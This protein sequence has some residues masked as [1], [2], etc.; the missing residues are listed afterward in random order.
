MDGSDSQALNSV[1]GM[2]ALVNQYRNQM[3]QQ[4]LFVSSGDNYIPGPRFNAA[5]DASLTSLLGTPDVGRAD[6]AL[7]NAMGLQ[8][9]VIGNHELDLGVRQFTEIMRPSGQWQG[10][11]FPYLSY[12]VD[13]SADSN[14]NPLRVANGGSAADQAGKLTGWTQVNVGDQIIGVIG[15]SSP[16]F[17]NITTVDNLDFKPTIAGSAIDIDGLAAEIQRGV[18]EMSAAGIKKIVLLSHMQQIQVEKQLATKL[19]NVDIIVAGGSNTL[20]ANSGDTLRTGDVSA[21]SY[22]FLTQS[23]SGQPVVVVNVDGDYKYL[24]RF[25]APFDSDGVLIP[26]RFESTQSGPK[27]TAVNLDNTAASGAV[28]RVVEIRDALRAVLAAKDGNVFG[29]TSVFLEGRRAFVRNQETNFGNLTA[30]ANLWYANLHQ[31]ATQV[32]ISLK[33]GGG[34]RAEIGDVAAQPGSVTGFTLEP[35]KENPG[36]RQQGQIS[37]LA[38]ETSLK[39]NN[40]LWV[41]DVT[42]EQLKQLLEHGVAALGSQGRFP[43]VGGMSF[44]YDPARQAQVLSNFVVTT[45]GERIRSLKVGSETVVQDGAILGDPNRNF[46]LVTLNFLAGRGDGYPFPADLANL[47]K[48]DEVMDQNTSGGAVSTSTAG[49]GRE[50]DALMKYLR[51][52]HTATPFNIPDTSE[53]LDIR[54]QNLSKR[55]DSLLAP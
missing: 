9:S 18:D 54:I 51:E 3:P 36:I 32:Q 22:P 5:N 47:V 28:Q 33:N 26:E 39:F 41:F 30:D 48:L 7:L 31:Q 4:T 50:Q 27:V 29:S 15:A 44:S 35:P 34:I 55:A 24:G 40:R 23:A 1:A 38:V 13:F 37:Q 43:Q 53:E 52:F 19:R 25:I 11:Q 12:N 10:A 14:A 20:L 16:V 8:A 17:K 6:I 21:G 49:F 42:A 45:P 2:S 46:R